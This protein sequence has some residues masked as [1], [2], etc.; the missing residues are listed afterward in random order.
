[1]DSVSEKTCG[2]CGGLLEA[3]FTT[4]IGLV[5]GDKSWTHDSQLVFVVLGTGTA[6]NPVKAIKQGLANE[7]PDRHYRVA[8]FRCSE[9]GALELYAEDLLY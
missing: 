3:G 5:A 8:G 2:K 6:I 9:C 4:A 7:P 1:M